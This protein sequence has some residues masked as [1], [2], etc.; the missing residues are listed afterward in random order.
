MSEAPEGFRYVTLDE[1]TLMLMRVKAVEIRALQK[2]Y[3]VGT[4]LVSDYEFDTK[5]KELQALEGEFPHLTLENTP[6][7]IVGH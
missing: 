5:F 7:R 2:A 6:T 4:P 3:Y 1:L